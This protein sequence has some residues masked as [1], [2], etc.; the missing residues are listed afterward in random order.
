MMFC[1][2]INKECHIFDTNCIYVLELEDGTKTCAKK[3]LNE[4]WIEVLEKLLDY[5]EEKGGEYGEGKG[6]KGI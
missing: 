5:L 4:L 1:P 3:Y 2:Y 6:I